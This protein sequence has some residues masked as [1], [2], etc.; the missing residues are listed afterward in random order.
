MVYVSSCI[1][2][3]WRL[4]PSSRKLSL[5][6]GIGLEGGERRLTIALIRF[7]SAVRDKKRPL[8]SKTPVK[9]KVVRRE[10]ATSPILLISELGDG[11]RTNGDDN[12]SGAR[13]DSGDGES[14][15]FK[16]MWNTDIIFKHGYLMKIPIESFKRKLSIVF[17]YTERLTFVFFQK[18]HEN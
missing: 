3:C 7:S 9:L 15:S 17:T 13:H 10:T 16:V 6:H 1:Y 14:I 12:D 8:E 11:A 18:N 2:D 4:A 5:V